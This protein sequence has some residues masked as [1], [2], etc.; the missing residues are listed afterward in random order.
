MLPHCCLCHRSAQVGVAP[1]VFAE[2]GQPLRHCRCC[3]GQLKALLN[4]R[5]GCSPRFDSSV[6]IAP[7][8]TFFFFFSLHCYISF[9]CSSRDDRCEAR[10]AF[11]SAWYVTTCGSCCSG[12][13]LFKAMCQHQLINPHFPVGLRGDSVPRAL[14]PSSRGS[15]SLELGKPWDSAVS[16]CV[17][18]QCTSKC[19]ILHVCLQ[20]S[21]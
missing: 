12:T 5:A 18:T 9:S 15:N 8:Q 1:W 19:S 21:I 4:L 17:H 14:M 10:A 7:V 11:D 6:G 2:G 16:L 13:P 20:G 3:S